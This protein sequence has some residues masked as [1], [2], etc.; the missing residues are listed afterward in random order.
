MV[1][2]TGLG[3]VALSVAQVSVITNS[4][5]NQQRERDRQ[6]ATTGSGPR[7]KAGRASQVPEVTSQKATTIEKTVDRENS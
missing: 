7:N 5:S 2:Q 1:E 4:L 3:S 6:S